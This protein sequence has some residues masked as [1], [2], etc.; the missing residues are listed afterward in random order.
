MSRRD[1]VFLIFKAT[2]FSLHHVAICLADVFNFFSM[3]LMVLPETDT[4]LSSVYIANAPSSISNG[5]SF[6]NKMNKSGPKLEPCGTPYLTTAGS[7]MLFLK[8]TICLRS[9]KY[10]VNHSS[11]LSKHL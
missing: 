10:E 8:L 9:L 2:L 11:V 3:S 4:V 1:F 7:D 6:T 5:M